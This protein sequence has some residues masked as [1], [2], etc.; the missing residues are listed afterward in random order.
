MILNVITPDNFEKKFAELRGF[1]FNDL[2]TKAE[3]DDEG[4]T[5]DEKTHK[6]GEDWENQEILDTIVQ[7]IFRKAQVEKEYTIFYGELC[8]AMIKLELSLRAEEAK[9]A[10]MKNSKFRKNIFDVC[11]MCFEKFF[12]E[13]ERKKQTENQEKAILF[14]AK[15]FGNLDFVGELYRRKILPETI[16]ISVFQ[17]LLGIS[18]MNNK[19]DDLVVEG[20]I[21][22]MNK[23]G[24]SFE[25]NVNKSK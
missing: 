8:Q 3:C 22:L 24:Q 16:L 17:S 9:I 21:T 12:D 6:L 13:E 7:N 19:I 20:A 25:E 14:K 1:L 4:I 11:K 2:R 23:V 15:L 10:N 18:E 5:Y